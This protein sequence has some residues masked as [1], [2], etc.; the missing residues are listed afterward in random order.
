[1]IIIRDER[2]L[3]E[4]VHKESG[5][6]STRLLMMD[7][8]GNFDLLMPYAKVKFPSTVDSRGPTY[9]VHGALGGKIGVF[10]FDIYSAHALLNVIHETLSP[11]EAILLSAREVGLL[12]EGKPK[13]LSIS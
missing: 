3:F 7:R 5:R 1:M 12:V 2:V 8:E 10:A 4:V 6:Q 11:D 13:V 9:L